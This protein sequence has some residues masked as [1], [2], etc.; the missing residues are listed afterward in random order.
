MVDELLAEDQDGQMTLK[1]TLKRHYR[2]NME[3]E[4]GNIIRDR[5]GD[6]GLRGLGDRGDH[7]H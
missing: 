3:V 6:H 5:A 2:N 1:E 4:Y 7:R